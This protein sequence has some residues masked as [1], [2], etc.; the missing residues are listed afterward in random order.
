[1]NQHRQIFGPLGA[2]A[3]LA[4][5]AIYYFV[6]PED[7]RGAGLIEGV[8]LTYGHSLCWVFLAIACAIW[9]RGGPSGM[10][11][12]FAYAALATYII[13]MITRFTF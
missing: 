9:W 6:I 13:F 7:T 12:R 11:S 3:A 5:A 2:L 4:V 1:M 8:I 10:A